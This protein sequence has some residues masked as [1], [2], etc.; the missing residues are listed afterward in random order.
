MDP[1]IIWSIF[2]WLK[3]YEMSNPKSQF[4]L[5]TDNQSSGGEDSL[6]DGE[7]EG[8]YSSTKETFSKSEFFPA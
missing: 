3:V 6:E 8:R 2:V 1:K 7:A 4:Y 5:M